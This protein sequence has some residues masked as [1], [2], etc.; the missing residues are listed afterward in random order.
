[1]EI[2]FKATGAASGFETWL[3]AFKSVSTSLLIEIDTVKSEFVTKSP[4][5]E[6][7]VVKYGHISFEDAGFEVV[8]MKD[9]DDNDITIEEWNE[10]FAQNRRILFGINEML[11]KFISVV[12]T[13]NGA[14]EYKATFKFAEIDNDNE[15]APNVKYGK[16]FAT[17][18]VEFKSVALTMRIGGADITEFKKRIS[19]ETFFNKV[20][21]VNKPMEFELD[22]DVVKSL[23][24]V[25]SILSTDAKKDI[26]DFKTVKEGDT[27]TLHVVDHTDASYDYTIAYLTA[28]SNEEP[29]ET[30]IPVNRNNFILSTKSDIDNE[31]VIIPGTPN[32]GTLPGK[33]RLDCGD[34]ITTIASVRV[35]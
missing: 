15:K 8:K 27:W 2:Q 17:T 19:D 12:S 29:V 28:G 26:M 13:F 23:V 16:E 7:T 32:D 30:L 1:M 18:R 14:S 6:K 20:C 3:N 4:S 24:S 9:A 22:L 35:S 5:E 11:P 21:V 33:V 31:K 10:Q 25:S 34:F